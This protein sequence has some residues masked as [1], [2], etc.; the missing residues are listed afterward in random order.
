[1]ILYYI[2][3]SM[4]LNTQ[5][6]CILFRFDFHTF[7]LGWCYS[8]M[9]LL[10][11]KRWQVALPGDAAARRVQSPAAHGNDPQKSRM[12]NPPQDEGWLVPSPFECIFMY[13]V[14]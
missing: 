5:F 3:Q 11:V 8:W 10:T 4:I 14:L 6:Y 9:S 7:E 2:L 13:N 12:T 1:M